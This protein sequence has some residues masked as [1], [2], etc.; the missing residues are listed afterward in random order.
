M[1][2]EYDVF[3]SYNHADADIV[4]E[5]SIRLRDERGLAVWLD[6]WECPPGKIFHED[7]ERGLRSS[8]A[9]AVMIGRE[10]MRPWVEQEVNASLIQ[11]AERPLPVIPVLLEGAPE[12]PELSL[13]LRTRTWVDMRGGL[14]EDAVD[15]L[16][17]G[18]TGVPPLRAAVE[19]LPAMGGATL[20]LIA[21]NPDSTRE[22][23]D[24]RIDPFGMAW[25]KRNLHV[26]S[27][28]IA[29]EAGCAAEMG[30]RIYP[31]DALTTLVPV[32]VELLWERGYASVLEVLLDRERSARLGDFLCIEADPTCSAATGLVS[33]ELL[34]ETEVAVSV[35]GQLAATVTK[36]DRPTAEA[37]RDSVNRFGRLGIP[38]GGS[39][40]VLERLRA[41]P[42]EGLK[43]PSQELLDAFRRHRD[44]LAPLL[45]RYG[46][47]GCRWLLAP[48]ED[49][50]VASS[51]RLLSISTN[52]HPETDGCDPNIASS[53]IPMRGAWNHSTSGDQRRPDANQ[54]LMAPLELS[55]RLNSSKGDQ[56]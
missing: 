40:S 52:E 8:K 6:L 22:P 35:D 5:L 32:A 56:D 12:E 44:V 42:V 50:D 15:Q 23:V 19:V 11:S 48:D 51:P 18:I 43:E 2:Q 1:E 4:T 27:E 33:A 41:I 45:A 13:F 26:A 55:R 31:D 9:V 47:P 16:E 24:V 25:V 28:R 46:L 20:G 30:R 49:Y 34:N 39:V 10:E 17:W 21:S 54:T 3:M 36:L 7:L 29:Q 37:V 38:T 53:E 14:T